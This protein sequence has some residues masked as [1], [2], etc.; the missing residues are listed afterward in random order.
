MD[1]PEACAHEVEGSGVAVGPDY[2]RQLRQL[3]ARDRDPGFLGGRAEALQNLVGPARIEGVDAEIVDHRDRPRPDAD[4]VVHVHRH[5]VEADRVVAVQRRGD[6]RLGPHAVRADR[7]G[8]VVGQF[9]EAGI[10]AEVAQDPGPLGEGPGGAEV[11]S[12][13]AQGLAL[14][15]N[16]RFLVA[17][18]HGGTVTGG[19]KSGVRG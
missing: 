11:A 15:L 4:E 18:A 17:R 5:A 13:C 14:P 16:P 7:D 6:H 3:T 12:H 2:A 19:E 8:E 9:D 10:V 1:R